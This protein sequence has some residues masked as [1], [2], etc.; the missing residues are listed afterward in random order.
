[1][2]LVVDD[3]TES[4]WFVRTILARLGATVVEASSAAA[5]LAAV[6]RNPLDLVVS[7][8]DMPGEDGYALIRGIRA[9]SPAAGGL[10][11]AIALTAGS[12]VEEVERALRA[13]FTA[14]L[15]KPAYALELIDMALALTLPSAA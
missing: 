2:I 7:D 15:A 1:M 11:P 12:R 13:G 4:R 8:V 5:A 10:V 6:R 9:L 14:H 3:D